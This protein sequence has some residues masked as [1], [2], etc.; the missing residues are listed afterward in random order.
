MQLSSHGC[1]KPQSILQ[2]DFLRVC[3]E[4]DAIHL[5]ANV[6]SDMW[7]ERPPVVMDDTEPS[8]DR[9]M[10]AAIVVMLMSP[11]DSCVFQACF[12]VLCGSVWGDLSLPVGNEQ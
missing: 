12:F 10:V 7:R 5:P 9:E 1:S 6:S 2:A 3:S 4:L 8:C 11:A